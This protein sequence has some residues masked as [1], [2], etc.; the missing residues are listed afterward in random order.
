M[1]KQ[2]N[3]KERA[4]M[5]R[6]ME[7]IARAV[8]DEYVFNSWLMSGVADGDIDGTE[9]DEDLDIYYEE[10]SDF[11][12]LMHTFLRVMKGAYDSGGLYVDGV[13]S[14]EQRY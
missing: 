5:I 2:M 4:D 6:A 9:T 14:K 11:A 7:R 10:D 8:N 12:D 3:T 1:A 13:V